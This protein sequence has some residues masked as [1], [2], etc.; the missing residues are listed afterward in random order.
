MFLARFI[1]SLR[2]Y[3]KMEHRTSTQAQILIVLAID[4]FG[5]KHLYHV[6]D[7]QP[8]VHF[9]IQLAKVVSNVLKDQHMMQLETLALNNAHK[10]IN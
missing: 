5:I 9:I 4:H 8:I 2:K 7:A 6:Q 10:V 1:T 3:V